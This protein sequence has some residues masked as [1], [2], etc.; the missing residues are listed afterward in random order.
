VDNALSNLAPDETK[1]PTAVNIFGFEPMRIGN[2]EHLARELS[3]QLGRAGWRSVLCFASAPPEPVREF[4]SL[5]N[6]V[7]EVISN[8][9]D[10]AWQ[11]VRDVRRILARYK[12]RT[13]HFHF[14]GFLGPY[15]WLGKLY[16]V[17]RSFYTD[18]TSRPDGYVPVRSALWKRIVA[19]II[20]A[21]LTH[22]ICVSDTVTARSRRWT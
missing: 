3:L 19:R 11:P 17:E 16:G 12:P 18:Q 9:W 2:G 5:P 7:I 1:I 14:T 21:P 22:T 13:L 15:P 8:P 10:R 4:L 6:V 20:N